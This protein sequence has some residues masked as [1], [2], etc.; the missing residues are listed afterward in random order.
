M[1]VSSK[2]ILCFLKTWIYSL[3]FAGLSCVC[4]TGYQTLLTDK[5][6]FTCQ[7][8]PTDN[9]VCT[10]YLR[11]SFLHLT[12]HFFS[13]LVYSKCVLLMFPGCH[14]RW[15][16]LYSLPQWSQ[17]WRK[18]PLSRRTNPGWVMKS[19]RKIL[20]QGYIQHSL[21]TCIIFF[22]G[23]DYSSVLALDV[24]NKHLATEGHS[25]LPPWSSL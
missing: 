14:F 22:Y 4:K 12:P 5:A 9:P 7:L 15:F 6:S 2:C 1:N 23:N 25:S 13:E 17:R 8:C 11:P 24:S 10:I 18:L 19:S 16:W 3:P 21:N 20:L